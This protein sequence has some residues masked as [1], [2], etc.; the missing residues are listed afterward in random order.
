MEISTAEG[1]TVPNDPFTI[2]IFVPDGDPEGLRIIDRMN[3]TG[4][5]IVFPREKWPTTKQRPEFSRAGVYILIGYPEDEDELPTVYVGEGDVIRNRLES[6]F[7]NKDFWSRAVVFTASNNSLNKA[8]VKW[9]E[10]ALVSRAVEAKQCI[11]DNGTE[12]Q[13]PWLSEAERCDT[14]GFLREILQ[15]LPLVGVRAF[16]VPKALVEPQREVGTATPSSIAEVNTVIVPAKPENFERVFLGE[17][18]WYAIRIAGGMLPKIKYIAAYQ[19]QPEMKVTH[20]AAVASIEPYGE[21]GKYKL[22]FSEPAK[23]IGPIPF[24]DAPSGSMT[25]Q[26]YTTIEKLMKAKKLTD[27]FL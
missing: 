16:E 13:E 14:Q 8:H 6:H 22:N 4:L 21:Q 12:P 3:W 23:P 25:G 11:L 5:G 15:I 24:G 26:R 7:Q 27:L 9:L 19:S 2:R 10:H 18:C 17:N 1:P 20:Y